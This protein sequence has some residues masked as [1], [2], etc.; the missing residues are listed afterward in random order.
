[1]TNTLILWCRGPD[2]N[3]HAPCGTQDFKYFHTLLAFSKKHLKTRAY[4]GIRAIYSFCLKHEK[5]PMATC[6]VAQVSPSI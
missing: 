6:S 5:G 4:Q 2:S 1:M 3:R